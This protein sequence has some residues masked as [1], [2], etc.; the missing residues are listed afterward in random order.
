MTHWTFRPI[1]RADFPLMAGW[2]QQPHVARWWADDPSPETLETDYGGTVDGT[3]PSEVFIALHDGAAAGLVQRYRLAAYPE[4][5]R[6]LG[7]LLP[8]PEEA[9]SMDYLVD[10]AFVGQGSA[11]LRAF[12][13]ALWRDRPEATCL[14]VPVHQGN[15][16]SCRALEKC[17]F[18]CV[19]AGELEPDNP[20]DS[21]DHFVYRLDGPGFVQ[22]S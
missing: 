13:A 21:K 4:Y 18:E 9:W 3:E 17:G 7:R 8:L 6:A 15:R 1:T 22:S 5:V 16:A 14:L 2:L 10:A 19:M 20:T 12:V 11:M